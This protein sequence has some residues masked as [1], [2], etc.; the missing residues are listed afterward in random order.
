MQPERH[1]PSVGIEPLRKAMQKLSA[2]GVSWLTRSTL[3]GILRLPDADAAFVLKH[4]KYYAPSYDRRCG[5]T[6]L[7]LEIQPFPTAWVRPGAALAD[8][9]GGRG[10]VRLS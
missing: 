8:H 3:I 1:E 4:W 10:A 5:Y 9:F 2:R 7:F 6:P